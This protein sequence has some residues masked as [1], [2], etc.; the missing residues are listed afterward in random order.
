M[1]QINLD[2]K[3]GMQ[4]LAD[5]AFPIVHPLG[6]AMG[7]TKREWFAGN[8][9]AAMATRDDDHRHIP[10]WAVGLADMLILELSKPPAEAKPETLPDSVEC[11]RCGQ[12]I[13][14]TDASK[15]VGTMIC[16]SCEANLE[17]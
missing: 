17:E 10:R 12:L 1:R 3:E 15:T 11:C 4:M 5:S 14:N 7:L 9:A 2:S 6:V 8:L 13:A 16:Q